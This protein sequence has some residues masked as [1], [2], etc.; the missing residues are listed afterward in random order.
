MQ[1]R[2]LQHAF[3]PKSIAI[4]GIS[5]TEGNSPPGYTGLIF[6]Q[7]LREAKFE[8]RI[9]PVNPKADTI[10]GLRAYPSLS[11][12]PEHVD[13]VIAAVPA[14]AVPGVLQDCV[15]AGAL[16]VLVCAAGFGETGEE[17]GTRL[18]SVIRDI[19]LKGGLRLVGPNALGYH[20]PSARMIM[21]IDAAS[22]PGP[23]ALVSQSGGICQVYTMQGPSQGIAFS[24]VI[25]YGNALV[26][27]ATDFLEYLATDPET[28]IIC[29]YTEGIRDGAKFKKLVTQLA[30]SKPVVIWK[31]GLTP[32]GARAAATHTGSMAGDKQVWDSFFSQTGA[33][34]VNSIAEM[35]D[36]TMTLLRLKPSPRARLAIWGGGGGN[37]VT[38]GDLCAEEGLE[39]PPFSE[40]T[41]SRLMEF[42]HLVNQI[43][44]NPIDAISSFLDA[45]LLRRGLETVAADPNIDIILMYLPAGLATRHW[46][47]HVGKVREVISD[48]SHHIPSGKQVVAAV[49][50]EGKY[51]NAEEFVHYLREADITTYNSLPRACRALARVARYHRFIGQTVAST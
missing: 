50:D 10:A 11:S 31:A 26:M 5:R 44:V 39:L 45:D 38:A 35:A 21:Y 13:Y 24:K 6:L 46:A 36:V 9:Y 27:D 41:K 19:A 3:Y 29:M 23:V 37:T 4:V 51:G 15:T 28:G 33:I 49:R 40:Q 47:E 2:G 32:W 7:F 17:E 43:I 48:L 12:V 25:S 30:P 14:S 34:R 16:D 20:V 42:M 18:D 22:T 8:G 1:D